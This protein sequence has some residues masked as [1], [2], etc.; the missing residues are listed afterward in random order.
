MIENWKTASSSNSMVKQPRIHSYRK[1][2]SFSSMSLG[3]QLCTNRNRSAQ[4]FFGLEWNMR[5]KRLGRHPLCMAVSSISFLKWSLHGSSVP[6][7]CICVHCRP[8][9]QRIIP[10]V[11]SVP[12][13]IYMITYSKLTSGIL[14]LPI[15]CKSNSLRIIPGQH[16]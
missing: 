12:K 1:E 15:W 10:Q 11:T 13:Y 5:A 4:Y 6:L 14:F 8:I 3:S 2:C 16:K 9:T 7:H